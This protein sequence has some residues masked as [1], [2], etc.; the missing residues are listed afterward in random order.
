K[1]RFPSTFGQHL[2]DKYYDKLAEQSM[3]KNELYFTLLLRPT[4]T[5]TGALKKMRTRNADALNEFDADVLER[6]TALTNPVEN[7][8]RKYGGE[9]LGCHE[10]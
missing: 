8:M 7:S 6:F 5:A 4:V 2:N 3:L 10:R 1:G 9:R